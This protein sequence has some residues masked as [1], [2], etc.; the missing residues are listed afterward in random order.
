MEFKEFFYYLRTKLHRILEKKKVTPY[1]WAFWTFVGTSFMTLQIFVVSA[2]FLSLSSSNLQI[3]D[4]SCCCRA[5]DLL[6]KANEENF[7]RP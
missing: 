2:L 3:L 5:V 1:L 4:N 7:Y 6:L